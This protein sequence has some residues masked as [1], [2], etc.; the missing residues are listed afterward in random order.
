[1]AVQAVHHF[2]FTV[3]DLERTVDFYGR[4]LGFRLIGRKHRQAPDLGDALRGRM[5]LPPGLLEA[6]ARGPRSLSVG[7]LP[8]SQPSPQAAEILIADMELAGTRVEFIQYVNPPTQPYPGDPA[9]AGSAHLALLTDDIEGE[10]RRLEAAG[11]RF[12]TPVRT[13]RDPGRPVWRWCYFRDPDGI[14]VELVQSGG[15]T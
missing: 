15:E 13:L 6:G 8:E 11:V 4:L 3:S 2:S 10:V 7:R 1:M 5:G 12:H 14:V 9:T